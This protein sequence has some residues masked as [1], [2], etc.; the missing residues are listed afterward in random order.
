MNEKNAGKQTGKKILTNTM[1]T[2]NLA[3]IKNALGKLP[4]PPKIHELAKAMQVSQTDYPAFRRL[5]KDGVRDGEIER[6]RGG[7]LSVPSYIGRIKGRLVIA[8]TGF[9]FVIPEDQPEEI[10][11]S[12]RDLAGAIHG[13]TVM[14]ELKKFR[15]GKSSEGRIVKVLHRENTQLVGKL[16]KGKFGWQ[17]DPTDPRITANIEVRDTGKF[18]VKPDYIA[19]VVLDAWTADYLPPTGRIVEVLGPAGSPGVDIDALVIGSGVPVEFTEQALAEAKKIPAKIAESEIKRRLDLRDLTIFTI[20]PPD[21]KDHDDAVSLEELE[22]GI[23]RLG[24]HIADVSYYVP[25]ESWLDKDALLR[26]NSIYLVDRVIPMLPEKLSADLCSLHEGVD[27]LCLSAFIHYDNHGKIIKSEIAESIIN[28]RASL[29]YTEVQK[30]LDGNPSDKLAPFMSLLKKMNVLAKKIKAKR[31]K[32]GSL[33]FDLPEPKVVLDPEGNVVEIFKYPRYDSHRLIEEFMLEAN[34]AVAKT[35]EGAAAP[36]LFRVHDKPDK[37]KIKNF[38]ELLLEMGYKFS[39][40]GDI[41][42]KKLQRVLED[43][44]GKADEAFVYKILLRSL[45]K[46]V[47][48]PN[49]IGHFGLAFDSY[50]HFTSPI[51]R[52]PDLHLH[53]VAKLFIN[54]KLNADSATKIRERLANIGQ[55]CSQTEIQADGLE[56]DSTKIKM[57]EYFG[58]QI[59]TQFTGSVS[60]VVRSGLF[61]EVDEIMAE[62]FL[63]YP[64]FGDD[65]YIY[66]EEKHQAI[67][68][69]T[70]RRF[71]L[72]DKIEIVVAKVDR[73]KR[74]VEFYPASALERKQIVED[75]EEPPKRGRRKRR[76]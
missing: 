56:R 50:A 64:A 48:Q 45:A 26:G 22:D 28:S 65:Y 16:S 21:A 70:R 24:V 5:L 66:D 41:T 17:L 35:L 43:V 61:V 38:A 58:N 72:G 4:S 7:R 27:R 11:I 46:A 23:N 34:K 33:D 69:R 18:A 59:G 57:V 73:E 20:D 14:V 1:T 10:F 31:V 47:Y 36:I 55:H 67:G 19:V 30:C 8:R 9:G 53:R 49:N 12:E 52:Y 13:E 39:F 3:D 2:Y 25:M 54:K 76:R 44:A 42:P 62:G 74:E 60:G 63:P 37:L 68:R 15:M 29:N 75:E 32:A 40:K 51:R 6:L 71:R